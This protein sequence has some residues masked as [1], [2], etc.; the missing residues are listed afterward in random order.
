MSLCKDESEAGVGG[1]V[2]RGGGEFVFIGVGI[3]IVEVRRWGEVC[4]YPLTTLQSV[5][6]LLSQPG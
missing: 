4:P 2:R 1:R 6:S 3:R 5:S